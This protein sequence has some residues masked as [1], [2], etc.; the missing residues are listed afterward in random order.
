VVTP[1]QNAEG[2]PDDK[3]AVDLFH[4]GRGS[5]VSSCARTPQLAEAV[6][7]VNEAFALLGSAVCA[8]ADAVECEHWR[9]QRRWL[10]EQAV[11]LGLVRPERRQPWRAEKR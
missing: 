4:S 1:A 7:L 5:G 11:E 6:I 2:A 8:S 3:A 9:E 10:R